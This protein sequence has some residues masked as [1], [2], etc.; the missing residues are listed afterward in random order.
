MDFITK[1]GAAD[2][3]KADCVAVGVYADGELTAAARHIDAASKG[4]VRAAIKSGDVTGL[5]GSTTLLRDLEGVT[6]SRV[7]LVGLG[8]TGEF[9]DK[10]YAEAARTSGRH[11]GS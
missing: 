7:L 10:A 3:V 6:A 11:S 5:R 8:R 2:S 9:T 1:V 4:A